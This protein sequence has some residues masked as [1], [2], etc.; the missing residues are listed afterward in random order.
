MESRA[1]TYSNLWDGAYG[2]TLI[3]DTCREAHS[4][5]IFA[6]NS[7]DDLISYD[8]DIED[9]ESNNSGTVHKTEKKIVKRPVM[10]QYGAITSAPMMSSIRFQVI[11]WNIGAIDVLHGRVTAKFRVTLFW[12]DDDY[13]DGSD[14]S[15][16]GHNGVVRNNSYTMLSRGRAV[17]D[18]DASEVNNS[19]VDIPPVSIVNAESFDVIG[20]PEV[21]VLREDTKLMR[22]TCLYKASLLQEN[23]KVDQFPHDQHELQIKIG[24]LTDRKKGQRWDKKV[25]DLK[26]ATEN[27]SQNSTRIPYGLIVDHV[28]IPEFNYDEREGLNFDFVPVSYGGR[29][30]GEDSDKCLEVS[31]EVIRESGYYDRNVLPLLALLN[32]VGATVLTM[33]AILFFQ[34]ALLLLNITFVQVGLRMSLDSKLP[35]VG[36]E[37]KMQKIM[38][39]YFFSLLFLAL[40]SSFVYYH[41]QNKSMSVEVADKIDLVAIILVLLHGVSQAVWYY[42]IFEFKK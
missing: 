8:N 11:V 10:S 1:V 29:N 24:I 17:L 22:W 15:A 20:R 39:N 9:Q 16:H 21:N 32:V 30:N 38:N 4:N 2:P 6:H 36:Y 12:N 42:R 19:K 26:L 7:E 35:S 27:D 18:N 25:W 31:L 37:I 28:K 41:L 33:H 14:A 40:E 23:M 3:A 5:S 34:R 13:S